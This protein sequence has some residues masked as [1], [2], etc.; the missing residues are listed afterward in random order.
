[1]MM[2]MMT[3]EACQ[4]SGSSIWIPTGMPHHPSSERRSPFIFRP[5]FSFTKQQP[6]STGKNEKGRKREIR[7]P[8]NCRSFCLNSSDQPPPSQ[9]KNKNER[10]RSSLSSF[11]RL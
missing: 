5:V 6:K 2:M 8:D 4:L 3:L 9:N 1:M 10:R 11:I 7:A